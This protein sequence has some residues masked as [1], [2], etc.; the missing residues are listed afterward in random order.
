MIIISR[1][2]WV[3]R[4]KTHYRRPTFD[5]FHASRVSEAFSIRATARHCIL[6]ELTGLS[7]SLVTVYSL[8]LIFMHVISL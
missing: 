5:L 4:K 8:S 1:C 7:Y 2:H 6:T 3:Q